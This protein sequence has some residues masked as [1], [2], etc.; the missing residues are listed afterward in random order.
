M[1]RP[2]NLVEIEVDMELNLNGYTKIEIDS[3]HI[4]YGRDLTRA[5]N[6]AIDEIKEIV[7]YFLDRRIIEPEGEVIYGKESCDYYSLIKIYQNKI[8]KLVFV[9]VL[10]RK[11]RLEL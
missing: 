11:T 9:S 8:Y 1:V 7:L 4:N 5:T 6:L 10:T 3:N 2:D